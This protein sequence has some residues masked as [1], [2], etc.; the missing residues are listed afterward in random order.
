M[1]TS[2]DEAPGGRSAK[3][4]PPAVALRPLQVAGAGAVAPAA[5]TTASADAPGDAPVRPVHHSTAQLAVARH[6]TP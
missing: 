3:L 6:T 4:N 2:S 5:A 1:E